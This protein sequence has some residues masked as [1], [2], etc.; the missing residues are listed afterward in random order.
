MTSVVARRVRE[1]REARGWS[2]RELA[3]RIL[4]L[5][6]K[7]LDR[8]VLANLETGRRES[9][10]VDELAAL[11]LAL[12]MTPPDLLEPPSHDGP[13]A[14]TPSHEASAADVRA[15]WRGTRSL[16]GQKQSP[17]HPTAALLHNMADR[18]DRAVDAGDKEEQT[19][20]LEWLSTRL[21]EAHT[22][23]TPGFGFP[24]EAEWWAA[25]R[26]E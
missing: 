4:D 24:S 23:L 10:T 6:Y 2:A 12:D 5:G 16:P 13:L 11:A 1:L 25:M 17:R 26:G 14:V 7:G 18:L 19:E 8:G 22:T 20:I 9:V 21:V 3:E 15:W